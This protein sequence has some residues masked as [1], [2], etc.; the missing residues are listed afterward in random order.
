MT[1]Q[2]SADVTALPLA[3]TASCVLGNS[4]AFQD[5]VARFQSAMGEVQQPAG[6]VE[7]AGTVA[8]STAPVVD[9]APVATPETLKAVVVENQVIAKPLMEVAPVATPETLKAAVVENQLIAKPLMDAAPV[10]ATPETLKAV[11]VENQVIAKPLVDAAPELR[12]APK[13]I[14]EEPLQAAPMAVPVESAAVQQVVVDVKVAAADAATA[15]TQVLVD[16]VEAVCDAILVTPGLLRGQGEIRIQLKPEV[17][18]GTEIHIEAKGTTLTV[19][20]NPTTQD[21]ATVLQQ[22]IAQFEQHL[23]GRIHTYQIAAR[24]NVDEKKLKS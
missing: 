8:T 16:A 2:D 7:P 15:R 5:A 24:V 14:S 23:A 20:F 9:A 4:A 10:V 3:E 18:S 13:T 22:N 21:A 19:A 12:K 11:V 6:T 1:F 17:L